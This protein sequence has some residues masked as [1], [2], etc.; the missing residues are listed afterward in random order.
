MCGIF[1]VALGSRSA[2]SRRELNKL[3]RE[4]FIYS[5]SRGR[6]AAGMACLCGE[7][8][9]VLKSAVPAHA[10]LRTRSF[11]DACERI[12]KVW[13]PGVDGGGQARIITGHSRL[14]TTGTH[15][16]SI[17][18]QPVASGGCVVV[19]NG[20]IVNHDALW[21]MRPSLIRNGAVD[22][23]V[24]AALADAFRSDGRSPEA[25]IDRVYDCI[26]GTASTALMFT[27]VDGVFLA[28]NNGSLYTAMA[29]DSSFL[30]LPV[31]ATFLSVRCPQM[32]CSQKL[33]RRSSFRPGSGCLFMRGLP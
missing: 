10:M 1:G 22:T 11:S 15:Y 26:D 3:L 33:N 5:E 18:N 4:L 14:V 23:E 7:E 17:N 6:E 9:L 32:V 20:I 27:D 12:G 13:F 29:A 2:I 24:L 30:C 25:A 28:T 21:N 31:S 16:R 8:L 19:H